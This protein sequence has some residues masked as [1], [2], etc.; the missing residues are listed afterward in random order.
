MRLSRKKLS[1][2]RAPWLGAQHDPAADRHCCALLGFEW[3]A[4][5]LGNAIVISH[6]CAI[7]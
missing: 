7:A 6:S 4:A 3:K 5:V 2:S 1:S